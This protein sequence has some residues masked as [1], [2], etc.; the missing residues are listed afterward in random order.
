MAKKITLNGLELFLLAQKVVFIPAY[1]MLLISDWHL[2]KLGH[3]RKE[4]LFVP[5]I[6]VQQDLDRLGALLQEL[7]VKEVVFLGDLF[8]SEWNEEWDAFVQYIKRFP[9]VSFT[10]TKGNHD[11]LPAGVMAK[12]GLI[13]KEQ[14]ILVEG[15]ILSHEPL[16]GLAPHLYNI[17]GHIHPGVLLHGKG[18]QRFRLPCFHLKNRVLTMPAFG[19]W[20]G[21]SILP[22]DKDS[23][24]YV[25]LNEDV[26]AI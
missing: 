15:V 16:L 9:Q 13:L 8:H 20:T 17:V 12:S 21:L 24:F 4:G 19:R 26:M 25:I 7:P 14:L 2:G 11:I 23:Q 6:P 22:K 10:L 18:R 5:P 3:F 1:Q